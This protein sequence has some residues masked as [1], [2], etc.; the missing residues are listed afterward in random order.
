MFWF[1]AYPTVKRRYSWR[2]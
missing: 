1:A 2:T